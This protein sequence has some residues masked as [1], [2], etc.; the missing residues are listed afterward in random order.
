[1][2]NLA[3]D[4]QINSKVLDEIPSKET[5]TWLSFSNEEFKKT[6]DKC[7]SSSI[8]GPDYIL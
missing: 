7:S 1:M 3:Q 8:H 2:L 4:Q 5:S 6:I